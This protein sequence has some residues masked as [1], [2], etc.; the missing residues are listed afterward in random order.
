[1]CVLLDCATGCLALNIQALVW[2]SFNDDCYCSIIMFLY[3][4]KLKACMVFLILLSYFQKALNIC[5]P[6]S[7]RSQ[8][9]LIRVNSTSQDTR[10]RCRR[11]ALCLV[12]SFQA[13]VCILSGLVIFFIFHG[14]LS[15]IPLSHLT[16]CTY[17]MSAFHPSIKCR[18]EYPTWF[19][20]TWCKIGLKPSNPFHLS[21][22]SGIIN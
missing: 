4:N 21:K 17:V 2:V 1:M 12:L 16:M 14:T 13:V 19:Y 7:P 9:G 8:K 5:F 11:F 18:M 10:K 6:G 15:M 3:H 22:C 20:L